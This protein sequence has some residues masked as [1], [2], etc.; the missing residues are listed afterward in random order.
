MPKLLYLPD[1]NVL[2]ALSNVEHDGHR[3]ATQW[4]AQLK[5]SQFLLCP[6]TESGLVRLSTNPL[7]G[8]RTMEAAITML[9][10]TKALP[11][12]AECPVDRSWLDLVAPFASRLHGYRQVT[13]ALLLGLAIRHKCILVTLDQH[14]RGLA[15]DEFRSSLLTL[16]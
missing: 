11:N 15:G 8:G 7:V 14:L 1:V 16:G 5:G 2:Y 6:I 12:C 4:F 10:D 9:L 3:R 13:D